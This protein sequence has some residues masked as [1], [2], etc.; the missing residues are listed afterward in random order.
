MTIISLN[1][2]TF[3]YQKQTDMKNLQLHKNI[4]TKAASVKN[5]GFVPASLII[6]NAAAL[7]SSK[8]SN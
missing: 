2:C 5:I 4:N 3:E 6:L 8:K 1:L 7:R